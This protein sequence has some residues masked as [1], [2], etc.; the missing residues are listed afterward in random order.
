M[1]PTDSYIHLDNYSDICA[2]WEML[3]ENKMSFF[4]FSL[5]NG[6][7]PRYRYDVMVARSEEAKSPTTWI[8]MVESLANRYAP[9]TKQTE[10]SSRLQAIRIDYVREDD[11]DE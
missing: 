4:K 9:L 8:Q 11:E 1:S 5:T 10:I 2:H 6:T 7:D 3:D